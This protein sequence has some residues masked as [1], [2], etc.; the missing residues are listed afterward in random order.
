MEGKKGESRKNPVRKCTDSE[1]NV[2]Q[3]QN[4]SCETENRGLDAWGLIEPLVCALPLPWLQLHL[5]LQTIVCILHLLVINTLAYAQCVPF[6]TSWLDISVSAMTSWYRLR[7]SLPSQLYS[8]INADQ[9]C[10]LVWYILNKN[11][12]TW[13]WNGEP[14]WNVM[15]FAPILDV[16]VYGTICFTQ[17]Q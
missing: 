6:K 4:R 11:I 3:W 8:P 12:N 15:T 7:W 1:I 14:K 10:V 2:L 17:T 13:N 5:L 16:F 9:D